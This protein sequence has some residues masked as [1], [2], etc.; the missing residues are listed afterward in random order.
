MV[1]WGAATASGWWACAWWGFDNLFIVMPTVLSTFV[2]A[3]CVVFKGID[4]IALM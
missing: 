3:V 4:E 1:L 2:M